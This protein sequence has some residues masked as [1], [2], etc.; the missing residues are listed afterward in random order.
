MRVFPYHGD[1]SKHKPIRSVHCTTANGGS[2]IQK[3]HS[4]PKAPRGNVQENWLSFE[5]EKNDSYCRKNKNVSPLSS[6]VAKATT[7][8]HL[9]TPG[10]FCKIIS[11]LGGWWWG[12][13]FGGSTPAI[14]ALVIYR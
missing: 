13:G 8:V 3:D 10:H 4:Q 5:K 11:G 2:I 9:V 14:Q 6:C 7:P 1:L 12:R